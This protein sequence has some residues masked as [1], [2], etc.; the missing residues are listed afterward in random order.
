M[1][2]HKI[3]RSIVTQQMYGCNLTVGKSDEH[4]ER[5]S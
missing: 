2:L 3:E 5:L 4:T 1:S